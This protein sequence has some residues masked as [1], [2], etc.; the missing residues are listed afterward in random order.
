MAPIAGV[1]TEKRMEAALVEGTERAAEVYQPLKEALIEADSLALS[2]RN[3]L[4]LLAR[5]R[6]KKP[7]LILDDVVG[8]VVLRLAME[9]DNKAS[10]AVAPV[11][12]LKEGEKEILVAVGNRGETYGVYGVEPSWPTFQHAPSISVTARD[13]DLSIAGGEGRRFLPESRWEGREVRSL[14]SEVSGGGREGLASME[15]L[16]AFFSSGQEFSEPLTWE[17]TQTLPGGANLRY[18]LLLINLKELR[19][20]LKHHYKEAMEFIEGRAGA[21]TAEKREKVGGIAT[22]T[23][24]VFSKILP[25]LL[26]ETFSLRTS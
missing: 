12:H 25:D 6:S 22:A 3:R 26:E 9:E 20:D 2:F 10:Y 19:G 23:Q 1:E 18:A 24:E 15:D 5:E 8:A 21:W 14:L 7:D 4:W 17:K 16:C 13:Q 11:V